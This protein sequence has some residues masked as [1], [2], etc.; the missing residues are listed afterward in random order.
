M[1][2]KKSRNHEINKGFHPYDPA[3]FIVQNV[4]NMFNATPVLDSLIRNQLNGK[5]F[6]LTYV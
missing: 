4:R 6:K 3:Q 2:K 1:E 5:I